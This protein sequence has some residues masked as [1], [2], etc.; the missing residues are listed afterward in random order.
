MQG[1]FTRFFIQQK[2]KKSCN[3][4]KF[5][6][7]LV[8]HSIGDQSSLCVAALKVSEKNLFSFGNRKQEANPYFVQRI[9]GGFRFF[10]PTSFV[11]MQCASRW[12]WLHYIV[13][14]NPS[15]RTF[16]LEFFWA[17]TDY[18]V[19]QFDRPSVITVAR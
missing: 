13:H 2:L 1:S 10:P 17:I 14:L 11:I 3:V 5:V 9:S 12:A 4:D 19:R 15:H 8:Q 18:S 6:P 16:S 7:S